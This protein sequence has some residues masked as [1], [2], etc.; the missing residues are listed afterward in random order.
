MNLLAAEPLNDFLTE[1]SESNTAVREFRLHCG[2]AKDVAFGRSLSCPSSR[3]GALMW[4]KLR[5]CDWTICARFINRRSFSADGGMRTARMA[6]PV[7]A[8][9]SK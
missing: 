3:S 2:Q 5:A 1:L 7:L 4:K 9:Q 6:S 8:E